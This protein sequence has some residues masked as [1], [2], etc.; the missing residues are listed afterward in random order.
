MSDK[1][2]ADDL[3]VVT[4]PTYFA[5]ISGI[6]A[7]FT[8]DIGGIQFVNGKTRDPHPYRVINSFAAAWS[9]VEVEVNGVKVEFS[10]LY[11]N[12]K[13]TADPKTK[14]W[15][16]GQPIPETF[17]EV[18]AIAAVTAAPVAVEA[19]ASEAAPVAFLEG[20]VRSKGARYLRQ[21]CESNGLPVSRSGADMIKTLV[22]NL[23]IEQILA[24]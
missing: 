9:P 12:T 21:V 22:A 20:V 4:F 8:G 19:A 17:V 18:A 24:L 1:W 11:E 5:I 2:N 10:P 16:Y 13:Y 14:F 6:Y 15:N 3:P 23:S 7:D